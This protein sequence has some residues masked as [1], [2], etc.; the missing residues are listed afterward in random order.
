[1]IKPSLTI[2]L[3]A[4]AISALLFIVCKWISKRFALKGRKSIPLNDIYNNFIK[5]KGISYTTFTDVFKKLGECYSINPSR[6]RPTDNFKLFTD[7]DSWD[8]DAG[9]EKMEKWLLQII[10]ESKDITKI[11]TVLDLLIL[12]ESTR[13]N[14]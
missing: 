6:I 3:T 14:K 12:V 2:V 7:I 4:I 13:K 5:D 1:M 9:T 8:L 11:K 10:G